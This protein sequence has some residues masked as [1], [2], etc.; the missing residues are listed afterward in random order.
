MPVTITSSA[1]GIKH[2]NEALSGLADE[3]G[4]KWKRQAFLA[5]GKKAFVQVVNKSSQLAPVKTGLL[6]GSITSTRGQWRNQPKRTKRFQYQYHI[7]TTL[8]NSFNA[9]AQTNRRGQPSRYPFMLEV[10][11]RPQTYLRQS[12]RGV[13][14]EVNRKAPRVPLLYMHRSLGMTATKVVDDFTGYLN[15]YVSFYSRSTY[16]TLA[17]AIKNFERTG[18][19]GGKWL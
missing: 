6:A 16:K 5:S 7:A 12:I 2:L 3:R 11:I 8:S 10:G 4:Q 15:T 1:I 9:R 18:G 14:H 19:K 13:L 17:P